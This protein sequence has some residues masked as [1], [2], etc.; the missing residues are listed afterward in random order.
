APDSLLDSYQ[1]ERLPVARDVLARSTD[2]LDVVMSPNPL[3]AFA[4]QRL[5]LPLLSRPRINRALAGRVSQIDV[6]Y[7][8]GPLNVP[9]R[10]VS[11]LRP[12]QRVPD[13]RLAEAESGRSVRLHRMMRG[14][15]PVL[16]AGGREALDGVDAA[17]FPADR[18]V[19]IVLDDEPY[20]GATAVRDPGGALRRA[21]RIERSGALLIRPDGHL[22]WQARRPTTREVAGHLDRISGPAGRERPP[23][24]RPDLHRD[25]R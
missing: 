4:V 14:P 21:L 13:A 2:I 8:D 16:L 18:L 25:G 10:R 24:G 5:V 1:A 19:V 23:S 12:G 3:V 11:R 7:P 17:A 22:L 6:G 9:G 15:A 20:T